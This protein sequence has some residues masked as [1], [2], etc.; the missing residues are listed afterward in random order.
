MLTSGAL[1]TDPNGI[2]LFLTS[3]D[4]KESSASAPTYCGFH[5]HAT[6]NGADIK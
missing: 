6:I 5:T 1:P 3:S 4:V 2:Y